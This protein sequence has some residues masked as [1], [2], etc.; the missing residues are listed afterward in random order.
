MVKQYWTVLWRWL[1]ACWECYLSSKT[2]SNLEIPHPIFTFWVEKLTLRFVEVSSIVPFS[3]Q[4]APQMT[5]FTTKRPSLSSI[6]GSFRCYYLHHFCSV[7]NQLYIRNNG[8]L[9]FLYTFI[10][11]RQYFYQVPRVKTGN[12]RLK[13]ASLLSLFLNFFHYNYCGFPR[14]KIY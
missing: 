1:T 14:V 4:N 8:V 7:S 13:W 9:L 11:N 5:W 2:D 3:E 12:Q 10:V 6:W